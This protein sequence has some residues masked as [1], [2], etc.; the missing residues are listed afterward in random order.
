MRGSLAQVDSGFAEM[1]LDKNHVFIDVRPYRQEAL[2]SST[3]ERPLAQISSAKVEKFGDV[4]CSQEVGQ[5][6]VSPIELVVHLFSV[7]RDHG[8]EVDGLARPRLELQESL[9]GQL[10]AA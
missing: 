7:E 5:G 10:R 9:R 1:K 3:E 8:E 2:S 4:V 6:L